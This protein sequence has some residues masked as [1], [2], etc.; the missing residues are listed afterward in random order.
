MTKD[1]IKDRASDKAFAHVTSC[2]LDISRI[3]EEL[4]VGSYYPFITK[5]QN[6]GV[7]DRA[8]TELKIWNYIT[9]LIEIDK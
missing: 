4:R 3:K 8:K 1:E 7:L 9:K 2:E 5:E 6:E